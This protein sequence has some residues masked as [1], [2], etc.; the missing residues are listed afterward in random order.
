MRNY[1]FAI[2]IVMLLGLL[3]CQ[4]NGDQFSAAAA[5]NTERVEEYDRQMKKVARQQEQADQ[6]IK[7]AEQQLERMDALHARWE[8]QADRYDALLSRWEAQGRVH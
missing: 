3:A 8:A 7:R 5:D 2:L 6:Q 4:R 1:R